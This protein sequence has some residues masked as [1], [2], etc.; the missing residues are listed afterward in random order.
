MEEIEINYGPLMIWINGAYALCFFYECLQA[1][2]WHFVIGLDGLTRIANLDG[3]MGSGLGQNVFC[4]YGIK[5]VATL[6]LN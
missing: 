3:W 2:T 4:W 1:V 6:D 5:R